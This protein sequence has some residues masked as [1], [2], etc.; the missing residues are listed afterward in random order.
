MI[1]AIFTEHG[2]LSARQPA[3]HGRSMPR[4]TDQ[5]HQAVDDAAAP[6]DPVVPAG[7]IAVLER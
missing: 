7:K 4:R 1:R 6:V 2:S 5:G 3:R